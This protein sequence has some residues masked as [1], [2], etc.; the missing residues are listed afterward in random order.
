M[1]KSS[2]RL[3]SPYLVKLGVAV[4]GIYGSFV[5]FGILQEKL[6]RTDYTKTGDKFKYSWIVIFFQALFSW[7]TAKAINVFYYQLKK[8]RRTLEIAGSDC[9]L[10]LRLDVWIKPSLEIRSICSSSTDE[11]F[12]SPF[13]NAGLSFRWHRDFQQDSVSQCDAYH[14]RNHHI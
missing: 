5:Y 11:I 2:S 4:G 8:N 1:T 7:L 14:R 12:K 13:R 9:S 6:Y 3:L 10:L